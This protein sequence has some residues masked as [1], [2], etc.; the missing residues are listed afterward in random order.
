MLSYVVVQLKKAVIEIGPCLW[1]ARERIFDRLGQQRLAGDFT[2]L[3]FE[4][5]LQIIKDLLGIYPSARPR[6]Q[7]PIGTALASQCHR[8]FFI[9]R[10][11]S[12]A[13]GSLA[14]SYNAK[15]SRRTCAIQAISLTRPV[16]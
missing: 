14:L 6:I 11:A 10:T 4:P 1:Q 8:A 7:L 5:N 3:F 13:T 15:N 16:R 2:Q 9:R 12:P